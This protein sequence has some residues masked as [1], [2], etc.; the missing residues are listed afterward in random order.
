M[1]EKIKEWIEEV[2]TALMIAGFFLAMQ[3]INN[4]LLPA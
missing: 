4:L 2:G 3:M 1:K